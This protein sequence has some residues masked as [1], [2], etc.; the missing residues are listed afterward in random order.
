MGRT[1]D[2]TVGTS[3]RRTSSDRPRGTNVGVRWISCPGTCRLRGLA[4]G[5]VGKTGRSSYR[6]VGPD[7]TK[8]NRPTSTVWC[9]AAAAVVVEVA[10]QP[11]PPSLLRTRT[12][13]STID[14]NFAVAETKTKKINCLTIFCLT[15]FKLV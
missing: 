14:A 7:T 5:W 8:T 2:S 9:T 4:R 3:G 13:T 6:A 12:M 15:F 10:Q 1:A 11:L